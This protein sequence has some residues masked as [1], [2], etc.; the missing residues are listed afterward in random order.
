M[1]IKTKILYAKIGEDGIGKKISKE[2]YEK[3]LTKN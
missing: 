2:S 1:K 3:S